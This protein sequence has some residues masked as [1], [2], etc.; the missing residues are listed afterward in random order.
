MKKTTIDTTLLPNMWL[1]WTTT[2][3]TFYLN[4]KT[5]VKSTE[6]PKRENRYD[7]D[8]QIVR[9]GSKPRYGYAKYH[10]DLEM[11]ELAEV[12]FDTTRKENI[13]EWK[14]A[15]EKYFL[16]KDKTV[17]DENGHTKTSGFVMS[18]RYHARDFY[19]FLGLFYRIGFYKNISEF[20]KFLGADTYTVGSGRVVNVCSV[21]HIQEWYKTKQKVRSAGKQTKLTNK[22]TAIPLTEMSELVA[23]YPI[24][25]VTN[26][27]YWS[28]SGIIHYEK[29]T[30]GWHVLRVL[31]P[32]NGS[33]YKEY[34]RMY[35]NDDGTNRIVAPSNDKWIPAKQMHTYGY[36]DFVNKDEAKANCNRL[37]YILPL[38]ESYE[39]N[40]IRNYLISILRFPEIEQMMRLGHKNVALSIANS[41]APKATIK[42][43]FGDY[44]NE[45]ETALLK[46][47]GLTKYQFDKYMDSYDNNGY[48]ERKCACALREMRELFGVNL[49]HLD[50]ATF[51]E[52]FDGFIAINRGYGRRPFHQL[53][54]MDIDRVKFVKNAFRLGKK[55]SNVYTILDDTLSR[56]CSLNTGTHPE[57]NWYFDSY[58]DVV[59]AHNAI[60]ELKRAQDAERRAMWDINE[61]KRR[62]KEEEKRVEIDKKRK[63]YEYEDDNY[64]IRL[65][66]NSNEIINEGNLQRICIGGYTT[67]HAIGNTNLFFLRPKN[68]PDVP[69]YA[70]EMDNNKR[71][72]QIH[73]YCN[74]WLGNNPDAIPT[75]VRWLR[76]NGIKCDEKILTCKATGYG[77]VNEYVKMPVVD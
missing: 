52:Y 38:I 10:A 31:S 24:E 58:S 19:T 17:L 42:Y 5:G 47:I 49:V 45:K 71:V 69:F 14:Y 76:K 20:K 26:R 54:N 61:A 63:V 16:K 48:Y 13:K 66:K 56:Y 35:L 51:D 6:A 41:N 8:N 39:D 53:E 43:M 33:T 70:I 1:T 68:N 40:K 21:W 15:G 11:L 37:K 4:C 60:D 36:F 64:M 73:G 44:Y 29:L 28:R 75:V 77:A 22:L 72:V 23:K 50:K 30:D 67:R 55:N 62:Q 18:E 2:K 57:I 9:S 34:E 25:N 59:R 12:T 7:P 65:P 74:R 3:E 32:D 46:K 27:N